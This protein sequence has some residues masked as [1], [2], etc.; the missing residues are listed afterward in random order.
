MQR[1]LLAAPRTIPCS[2]RP[3]P[4]RAGFSLIE[5]L[6]VV[7]IIAILIG[8]ILAAVQPAR[9]A[10]SRAV[11]ANNLHQIGIG[12]NI[13]ATQVG[14]FPTG[15]WGWS[16]VGDPDRGTDQGQTGGWIYNL[17]P[18]VEQ[19]DLHDLGAGQPSPAKDQAIV[20]RLQTP[21]ST[22]NCPTRRKG[23]PWPNAGGYTFHDCN[24]PVLQEARTDYAANCGDGSR[25]EIYGGPGSLAEGDNP[26]Y[27]W[28]S[29][30]D[31]TGISFQRSMVR[32]ED[33]LG[34]LSNTIYASEKYLNPDH[35]EKGNDGSDNE[36]MYT[37]FNNDLFRVTSSVP[38][39]DRS[40]YSNTMSFGSAHRVGLNVLY[41][42]GSVRF[43]AYSI[44][45]AVFKPMGNRFG[46]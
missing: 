18:Y 17:L 35:Y 16:W 3:V 33:V 19:Q 12:A 15:G 37:G 29:T 6:V 24:A 26:G 7:L 39:Q 36:S 22:F 9:E 25:D 40:G 27:A 1:T 20:Q 21:V 23:G 5:L 43:T 28:P 32:P 42:D 44:S 11:C 4:P 46:K 14:Y 8:L 45:A 13:H 10:A 34:G 30:S 41:C 2:R 38:V 31:L